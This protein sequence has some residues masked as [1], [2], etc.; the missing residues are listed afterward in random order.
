MF[1][2]FYIS[3]VQFPKTLHCPVFLKMLKIYGDFPAEQ[4]CEAPHATISVLKQ[5]QDP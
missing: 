4:V 5:L 1:L 3:L 2:H